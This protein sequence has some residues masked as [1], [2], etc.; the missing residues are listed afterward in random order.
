MEILET[1][2]IVLTPF[3][4]HFIGWLLYKLTVLIEDYYYRKLIKSIIKLREED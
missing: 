1:I 4:G 2:L 3:V